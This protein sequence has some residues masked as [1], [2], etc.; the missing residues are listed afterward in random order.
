VRGA[1]AVEE[2][3]RSPRGRCALRSRG[4]R[5]CLDL[6]RVGR[7]AAV[8]SSRKLGGGLVS[9]SASVLSLHTGAGPVEAETVNAVILPI[10]PDGVE[11]RQ[12]ADTEEVATWYSS[13]EPEHMLGSG[14]AKESVFPGRCS[15]DVDG[16]AGLDRSNGPCI[17]VGWS[18]KVSG[19]EY[20]ELD[21]EVYVVE[22]CI[23]PYAE[24]RVGLSAQD[25]MTNC[26]DRRWLAV[27]GI[28]NW[29]SPCF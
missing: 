7:L 22:S 19:E 2:R 10:G 5:V 13:G 27:S 4:R 29:L 12:F 25:Q 24:L 18:N 8:E 26:S 3:G 15:L 20:T 6:P 21:D 17:S 28:S 9:P 14:A 16:P 1:V 11:Y 23:L